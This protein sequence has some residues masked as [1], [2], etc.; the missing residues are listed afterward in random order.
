MSIE[1][2]KQIIN[3]YVDAWEKGEMVFA[4]MEKVL[5][6]DPKTIDLSLESPLAMCVK[7]L[8]ETIKFPRKEDNLN[9]DVFDQ[10]MGHI[11]V[12]LGVIS[13]RHSKAYNL[14]FAPGEEKKKEGVS[15]LPQSSVS[16]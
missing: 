9:E 1:K 4:R 5:Q 3:N 2:D 13:S 12:M 14:F 7:E 8:L 11:G 6:E 16:S 15:L 10:I